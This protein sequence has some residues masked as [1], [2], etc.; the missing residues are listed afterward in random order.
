MTTFQEEILSE[1]INMVKENLSN[2]IAEYEGNTSLQAPF[3]TAVSI[4]EY[5]NKNSRI[6]NVVLSPN[7]DLSFQTKLKEFMWKMLIDNGPDAL[8]NEKNL[9][10]PAD[11]LT[12]YVA[13]AHLGIIQQ[14]L[15]NGRKESPEEMAKI[16]SMLT[17]N[18]PYFAAG[19]KN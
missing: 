18:G 17:V 8:I 10:V 4:F 9:L 5:I 6:M 13:S 14:W 19:L 16:L 2:V 1:L 11:Y 15:E 7:G 3:A 12:S